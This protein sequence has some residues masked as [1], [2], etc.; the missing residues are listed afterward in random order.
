MST[1]SNLSM[2]F[3]FLNSTAFMSLIGRQL[4]TFTGQNQG[5]SMK[6]YHSISFVTRVQWSNHALNR[7]LIGRFIINF[8]SGY[9]PLAETFLQKYMDDT[10]D[11]TFDNIEID[12]HGYTWF[13]G[14]NHRKESQGILVRRLLAIQRAPLRNERTLS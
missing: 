2:P 13:V 11:N 1:S 4:W 9:G 3:G 5:N 7:I 10:V 6:L 14:V 8:H 12:V